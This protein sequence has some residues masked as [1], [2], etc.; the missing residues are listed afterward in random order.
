MKENEIL[1]LISE[2]AQEENTTAEE[3]LNTFKADKKAKKEQDAV[4]KD[5]D[6]FRKLFPDVTPSDIPEEVWEKVAAG[7]SL[8]AAYALYICGAQS[9]DKKAMQVNEENE[10]RSAPAGKDADAEQTFTPEQVEGMSDESVKKNFKNII[11]SIKN[12]K[13]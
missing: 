5:V 12:W 10:R 11:R 6:E 7:T 1:K 9:K 3:L 13:I 2:M 8:A 4:T